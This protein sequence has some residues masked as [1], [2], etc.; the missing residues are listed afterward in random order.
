MLSRALHCLHDA[1]ALV[2]LESRVVYANPALEELVGAAR[3]G[4][5]G[6][7]LEELLD[8]GPEGSQPLSLAGRTVRQGAL[9]HAY[10][11]AI[12]VRWSAILVSD[13]EAGVFSTFTFHDLRAEI[14]DERMGARLRQA[15]RLTLLGQV[16]GGVAHEIRNA[17]GHV[18]LSAEL[19]E[20]RAGAGRDE[21]LTSRLRAATDRCQGML[22][23][24]LGFVR[25][26]P[27]ER[28]RVSLYD[29]VQELLDIVERPSHCSGCGSTSRSRR[30]S[31]SP[32]W[33]GTR[34]SR[35]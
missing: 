12:P 2:D 25:V 7:G 11:E 35:S 29:L 24:V 17:L 18:L 20:R 21:A 26:R 32:S 3:D 15:E 10:G 30:V 22:D 34:S 27:A 4:L 28:Q 5:V 8:K 1:V 6:R 14:Q 33:T 19:L 31:P 23:R 13:S 16:F 9:R